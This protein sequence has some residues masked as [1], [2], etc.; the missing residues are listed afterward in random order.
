MMTP[1]FRQLNLAAH[2]SSSVG[3]LGAAAS[4]LILS[5][6]GVT[7]RDAELVRGAYLAMN[8]IGQFLIVP[9]SLA[10]LLTGLVLSLGTPWGLFRYYWVLVK[11]VLTVLA[12]II[13]L[14]HQFTAVAEAARRVSGSAFGTLPE[15]GRLGTQLVADAAAALIVLLLIT[16]LGVLKPWGRT[17]YGRRRQKNNE[18]SRGALFSLPDRPF[19]SGSEAT[20]DSLPVGLKILLAVTGLIAAAFVMIH[21]AGGGLGHYHH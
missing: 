3:W 14:L 2:I 21:L 16:V 7:S 4:F 15:V 5:V 11:F 19:D 20:D 6:A 10:A 12:T 1:K 9:L 17:R 8:L 13:L 18:I